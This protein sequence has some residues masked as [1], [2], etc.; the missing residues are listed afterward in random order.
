[1]IGGKMELKTLTNFSSEEILKGSFG[2]EWESL[3]VNGNGELSLTPHPKVFGDKLK[4]PVITTDFSESQ[5]EM[6]TPTLD[7]IDE[8]VDT[9]SLLA[10]LVNS[11][12]D[13]DEYLWFQSLPCILPYWDKIPIAQYSEIG[14][15]S[16]KYREDLA[17]KYGV[18]KQMISG[19]HFNFSFSDEFLEK[20]RKLTHENLSIKEFKNIVYLKIARNYIRYC[21]LIIYLTGCSIAAH[22]S[23]S[24]ECIHLMDGYDNR[25]SYYS[26]KGPSYR[27][28]SCG[29]KNLKNLFP[30]YD[31]VDE[32]TCDVQEFIDR[33]DLSEAKELYT[34]IRLKPKHPEDMLN[35]LRKDGIEYVEIRS[36][37]INP[38][39]KSGLVKHD[40]K[41]LHLF[42]IYM[43]LK[44]EPDYPDWQMEAKINEEKAAEMAYVDSMRLLRNGSEVTLK[45][46]AAD[47]INEMY[48][49]CEVLG[50]NEQQ[51]LELILLRIK[52]S[53]LTYGKRLLQL[54]K[55]NGFI[56]IHMKF[57]KVN[58]QT[59]IDFL[60]KADAKDCA[61]LKKYVDLALKFR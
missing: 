54:I 50:I 44:Q 59:S 43:L 11:S 8:A 60:K 4:N 34:Q 48:G 39:Y 14:K 61:K 17:K 20:L 21:W 53:N 55:N 6:I 40:M 35:S 1:M 15:A 42:L 23:F 13:S 37:D 46:W 24:N 16:Q 38:F 28:S 30:S 58:K 49:M 27:N 3:R 57:S 25:G 9:F 32:F 5:I 47:I 45:S 52:D 31:S 51:T 36:L 29:Y 41:F 56:N 26:T 12:L 19:V 7:T 2:I 22:K 10:D 33:G 18:K